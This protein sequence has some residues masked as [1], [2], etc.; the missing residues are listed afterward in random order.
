MV[1]WLGCGMRDWVDGSLVG[2]RDGLGEEGGMWSPLRDLHILPEHAM[3]P[4]CLRS[5]PRPV[6]RSGGLN[7]VGT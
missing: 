4:A 1:V 3:P 5:R 2:M 6:A 7:Q